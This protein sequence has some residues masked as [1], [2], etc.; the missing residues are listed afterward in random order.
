M[1]KAKEAKERAERA[2][3]ERE[4]VKNVLLIQELLVAI[5]TPEVRKSLATG[6]AGIEVCANEF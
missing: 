3:E 6:S 2:K 1:I 4:K 5:G